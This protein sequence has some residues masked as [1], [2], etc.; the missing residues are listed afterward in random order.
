MIALLVAALA[1]A[2]GACSQPPEEPSAAVSAPLAV[3]VVAVRRGEI[4]DVLTASGETAALTTLRLASPVA[5]RITDLA[6]QPGDAVD[7]GRI[8]ARVLPI[9]NEAALHGFGVLANAGALDADERKMADRLAR[10]VAGHDVAL[11]APF[12]AV[13]AERLHN[14]GEQV[15]PSDALVEL[16]DPRSLVVI[17]QVPVDASRDVRPGQAVEI[18]LAGRR[19]AAQVAAVLAAVTPQ[20]LTVPVRIV[21]G[22][23]LRPPLLHAAAECRITIARHA[24]AVLIPRTSV[25][26]STAG[27]Q[28]TVMVATEGHAERR[29]VRLG[30]RSADAVEVLDGLQPGELVLAD[31]GYAL[32]DGAAIAPRAE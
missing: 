30:V 6:V 18:S 22:E 28:G 17:A 4:T 27:A 26:G 7:A 5:G 31:G 25:Q 13:V 9:E 8:V 16:F 1:L 15:A 19:T 12:A 10:D 11:R 20:A 3:R 14:P 32:A 2:L 21:P 24:D 23:P 29:S